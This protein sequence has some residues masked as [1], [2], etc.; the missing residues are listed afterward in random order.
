MSSRQAAESEKSTAGGPGWGGETRQ[1]QTYKPFVRGALITVLT[2]GCTLGAINLAVMGFGADLNAV[3]TPLIQS[4][5]YAQVFGWVGLFIM[6]IAYHLVPRFYLRPLTRPRLVL[7]SFALVASGLVVRFAAQPFAAQYP[8]AAWLLAV[9]AALGLAGIS[10][11][12][13]AMY[14]TMRHGADR[15]SST[16]DTLYIGAGFAWLWLGHAVTLALMLYLAANGLDA[17]PAALNAPYLRAVLSGAIVTTILGFTLRTVPHML[18]LR[19][20]PA[21]LMRAVFAAYTLAVLGQIAADARLAGSVIASAGAGLELAALLGFAGLSGVFDRSALRTTQLARKNPWPERFV[22]TAYVWLL[23]SAALNF[24][25]SVSALGGRTAPHAFVASYHHA[26]TVGFISMMIV[27]M[28]MRLVPVFIGAMNRQT[29]LAGALF[30]LLNLGCAARVISEA[31]AYAYGGPFYI[32]MGL[33]GLVE[34]GGLALYAIA[35]WRAL[36]QPS[37]G[38]A[39]AKRRDAAAPEAPGGVPARQ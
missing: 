9:S 21:G 7:P 33:S 31:M 15:F 32:A 28:S 17:I 19:P 18:G 35:L 27:G 20:P 16:A 6:G 25:Y 39:S 30:V 2:I 12:A 38:Q 5:G 11:F 23:V 13:W 36:D 34:V 26:L 29:R 24:A 4:H 14:D 37:Y 10:L 3:W 22:R 8:A 1:N